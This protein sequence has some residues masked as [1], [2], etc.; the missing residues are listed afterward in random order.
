[1]PDRN[2]AHRMLVWPDPSRPVKAAPPGS[3]QEM[4][5]W[6]QAEL[7]K[8]AEYREYVAALEREQLRHEIRILKA[9]IDARRQRG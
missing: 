8:A 2:I 4:R 3:A 1:M 9:M 6:Q 5:D 7:T